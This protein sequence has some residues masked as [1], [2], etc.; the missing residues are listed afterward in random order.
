M[1]NTIVAISDRNY[2]WGVWLLIASMR[3]NSMNEPVLV[4]GVD[5]TESDIAI[6]K[7]FTDVQI[8][9]SHNT[10][11]NLTC[12]KPAAM[13]MA[14]T[15]YITWVDCDSIFYGNCSRYLT[16]D[17]DHIHVEMRASKDNAG[18]FAR[19]Y[20]PDDTYGDIPAKIL[21]VWRQDIGENTE[22]ALH[23]CCSCCFVSLHRSHRAI[24]EKWRDQMQKV[25]PDDNVGVYDKRSFAYFQTDESVLNSVL[26]FSRVAVPPAEHYM[27]AS[28]PD[29]FHI[30]FAY[31]PKPWRM[32][33][34]YTIQY[35]D[36][37]VE[38]VEW[39][40]AQGYKTPGPVPVSLQRKYRKLNH[41]LAPLGKN[42]VRAKKVL[43]R[44][45][46]LQK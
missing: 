11:R 7:Q 32:W 38:L 26:F 40:V 4:Q 25:L 9:S 14:D 20:E 35:F 42:W 36:K 44:L 21:D 22:P 8:L 28:D 33:N 34:S 3:K 10:R 31:Q 46:I 2:L 23:S 24:L 19:F 18:V 29:A 43:R 6:L 27:L 30:H 39:A 15:D 1:S 37:T 12:S 13:L 45:G 41:L 17:P 16:A 5:Y